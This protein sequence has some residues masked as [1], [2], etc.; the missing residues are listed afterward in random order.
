M[1]PG[2]G[3]SVAY[4]LYAIQKSA[5]KTIAMPMN[6]GSNGLRL[7]VPSIPASFAEPASD[8]NATHERAYQN[9]RSPRKAR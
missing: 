9:R 1:N 7:F 3:Q 5:T 6:Q 4:I 8:R 2:A